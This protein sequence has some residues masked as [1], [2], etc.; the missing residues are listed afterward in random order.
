MTQVIWIDTVA[1]TTGF[2]RVSQYESQYDHQDIR[3][4]TSE[5][6][7]LIVF[8]EIATMSWPDMT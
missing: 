5:D 7:F 2:L 4:H 1:T 3:P 8:D 6:H